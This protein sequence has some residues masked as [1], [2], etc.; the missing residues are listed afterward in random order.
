MLPVTST[1][2]RRS[3]REG[4]G[5]STSEFLLEG[6]Y[7]IGALNHHVFSTYRLKT[8]LITLSEFSGGGGK[9]DEI[10]Q[11]EGVLRRAQSPGQD[12]S[13]KCGK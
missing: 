5:A 10:E 8:E 12:P 1:R 4:T 2:A 3:E 9:E 7:D 6:R 13:H 11:I